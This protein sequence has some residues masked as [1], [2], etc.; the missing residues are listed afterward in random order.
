MATL[1]MQ[2]DFLVPK[3]PLGPS[4]STICPRTAPKRPRKTPKFVHSGRRQPQTKDSPKP[5][6]THIL[7]YV[8]QN[9]ISSAP[10]PPATTH[11][12]WFPTLKIA[13]TDA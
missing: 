4:N 5:K 12:W 7:G 6:T 9:A 1:H 11:F 8:A 3:G 10:N 2:L 13:L